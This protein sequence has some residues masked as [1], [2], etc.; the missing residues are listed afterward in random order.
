MRRAD[1]GQGR[2]EL[3][4][5]EGIEGAEAGGEF[6]CG[7]AALA[8]EAAEKIVGRVFPFL[9]VAFHATGDQIAVGI[10]A[11]PRLGQDVVQALHRR[12]SAAQTVEALAALAGVDGLSQGPILEKVHLLDVYCDAGAWPGFFG[13]GPALD[14]IEPQGANLAGE[15]H[16]RQVPGFVALHQAQSAVGYEPAHGPAHRA[17]GQPDI[18]RQPHKRK[19]AAEF[20]FE[21]AVPQEM[22]IDRAVDDRQAQAGDDLI[23]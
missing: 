12:R 1:G 2:A 22:R 18:A 21:A 3:A 8:V 20:P 14:A 17:R 13:G 11:Q 5:G 15:P 9:R 6:A 19:P 7:Q 4:G 23:F 16:L 10:A